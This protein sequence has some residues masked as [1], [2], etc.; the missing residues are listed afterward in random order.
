M[1]RRVEH[2]PTTV[3][4]AKESIAFLFPINYP[5]SFIYS[6]PAEKGEKE[7]KQNRTVLHYS[8]PSVSPKFKQ[9]R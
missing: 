6:D 9:L 3:S 2:V 4:R 8:H 7:K 5:V 1:D